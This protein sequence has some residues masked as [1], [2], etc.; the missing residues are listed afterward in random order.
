MFGGKQ[1]RNSDSGEIITGLNAEGTKCNFR[2]HVLWLT[3]RGSAVNIVLWE[4]GHFSY[5]V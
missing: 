3:V 5:T 4:S 1:Q 2:C